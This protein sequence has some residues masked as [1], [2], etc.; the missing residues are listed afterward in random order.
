[1]PVPT[2]PPGRHVR[3][4][5]REPGQPVGFVDVR[6]TLPRSPRVLA[7]TVSRLIPR[8]GRWSFRPRHILAISGGAA[9]GAYGAGFLAGLSRAGRRPSFDLVTGVSTGALIAPFAFLGPD[10]DDRLEDAYASGRAAR[11]IRQGRAL[12]GLEHSLLGAAVLDALITPFVDDALLRAI[13][14]AHAEGRRLFV[15]TTDLDRQRACVWDMGAIASQS[16]PDDD[17]RALALFRS[18]LAASAS[19][20]GVFPPRM[21]SCASG[22]RIYEEMHVDGGVSA[23]LFI[24]PEPLLG[25]RDV[26]QRL[27]G[28]HV[29][30]IVNTVLDPVPQATAASLP[31]ILL[32]SFDTMLRQSYQQAIGTAAAFCAGAGL[33]LSLA[34]IPSAPEPSAMMNFDTPG[35]RRLFEAG[36]RRA[37]GIDPWSG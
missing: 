31:V 37:T 35:M 29:H 7:A 21:I 4:L 32:R 18:V 5:A 12:P 27:R 11:A 28:S 9:G 16:G 30:M 2:R 23:P 10:W 20:P 22:A 19:L 36:R 1:M 24:L 25:R 17:G 3:P 34:S 26:G 6:L 13:A 15:T 14:A 8:A 33:S